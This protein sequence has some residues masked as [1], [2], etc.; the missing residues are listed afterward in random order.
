MSLYKRIVVCLLLV[1]LIGCGFRP[2]YGDHTKNEARLDFLGIEIAPI[3]DR[4]GHLLRNELVR[5]LH[6]G[7][8]PNAVVYRLL[9]K[10]SESKSSLAVKKSAFAT[11][12][13]LMISSTFWLIRTTDGSTVFSATS[14]VTVSYN[15]LDSEFA[16]LLSEKNARERGVR[17]LSEDMRTRLGVFFD[18]G[19]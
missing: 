4:E 18:L 19:N 11:R 3:K 10:L 1:P 15:I 5:R 2:L 9:N 16:S 17:E 6:A 12:G 13:N 8:K 7:G 14:Q